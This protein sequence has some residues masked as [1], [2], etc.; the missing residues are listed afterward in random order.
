MA[1]DCLST[2]LHAMASRNKSIAHFW[3][4]ANFFHIVPL[5]YLHCEKRVIQITVIFSFVRNIELRK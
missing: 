1:V 4:L 3:L 5:K 2:K